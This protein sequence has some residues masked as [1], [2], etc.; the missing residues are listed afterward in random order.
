MLSEYEL[1]RLNNIARNHAVLEALGLG[2]GLTGKANAKLNKPRVVENPRSGDDEDDM[3]GSVAVRRST[4]HHGGVQHV[5]LTD[6][7]M[8]IEERDSLRG[9]RE[10]RT[11]NRFGDRQAADLQERK[12][13]SERKRTMQ[14]QRVAQEAAASQAADDKANRETIDDRAK[15]FTVQRFSHPFV[16]EGRPMII[17]GGRVPVASYPTKGRKYRCDIC[18]GEFVQTKKGARRHV[19]ISMDTTHLSLNC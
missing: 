7:D 13:H 8:L 9:K 5:Q 15:V 14:R 18:G 6:E 10:R 2:D 3:A 16:D 17:A 19:C 4:R 1:E 12:D 11:I